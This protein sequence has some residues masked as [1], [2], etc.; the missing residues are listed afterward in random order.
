MSSSTSDETSVGKTTILLVDDD[1]VI[2]DVL[3]DMLDYL[4]YR[5]IGADNGAEAVAIYRKRFSEIDLVIIDMIMP[6]MGGEE[7]FLE[8]QKI[9][10]DVL[11]I[12]STGFSRDG[13]VDNA[14]EK[15][16]AAFI[17]KPYKME[18]LAQTISRVLGLSPE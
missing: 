1:E 11:A 14:M 5:V 2:L 4:G 12:L 7:T 18:H 16:V 6:D 8:M 13:A 17:Q 15:G 9:N 3:S 10:G